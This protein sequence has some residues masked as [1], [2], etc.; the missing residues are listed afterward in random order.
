MK[1]STLLKKIYDPVYSIASK[2]SGDLLGSTKGVL[3]EQPP[4][5]GFSRFLIN[6]LSKR[7][8]KRGLLNSMLPIG[9]GPEQMGL[10]AQYIKNN[11]L[12]NYY[13]YFQPVYWNGVANSIYDVKKTGLSSAGGGNIVGLLNAKDVKASRFFADQLAEDIRSGIQSF[14]DDVDFSKITFNNSD[15]VSDISFADNSIRSISN[16]LDPGS[17]HHEL[18]HQAISEKN[19][20]YAPLYAISNIGTVTFP[21]AYLTTIAAGDKIKEKIDGK[22]DDKIIDTIKKYGPELMLGSYLLRTV[23]GELPASMRS[24]LEIQKLYN[25][26]NGLIN[27]N[28]VG[29]GMFRYFNVPFNDVINN[30]S[31]AHLTYLVKPVA[32]YGG[33]RG[34]GYIAD[35]ILNEK[36]S[37]FAGPVNS[38]VKEKSNELMAKIYNPVDPIKRKMDSKT[39]INL[40]FLLLSA[41]LFPAM[42]IMIANSMNESKKKSIINDTIFSP[43]V[44]E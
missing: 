34:I 31:A 42:S 24:K 30:E 22:W 10:L 20:L 8:T 18:A 3:L 9:I 32:L 33:L 16:F 15:S 23:A 6:I 27:A 4:I 38:Y 40:P 12:D 26:G 5:S 13:Q 2:A 29:F 37:S 17:L 1:K 7:F 21:T 14:K 35:D 39:L 28:P 36:K 41:S 25:S 11:Q 19:P 44:I 43:V